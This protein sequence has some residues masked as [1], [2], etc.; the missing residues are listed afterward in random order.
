MPNPM[1][2]GAFAAEYLLIGQWTHLLLSWNANNPSHTNTYSIVFP[3]RFYA[4]CCFLNHY[5]CSSDP[6]RENATA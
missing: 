3:C 6:I 1:A 4:T 5:L 2:M